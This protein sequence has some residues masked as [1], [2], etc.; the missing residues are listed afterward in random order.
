[1]TQELKNLNQMLNGCIDMGLLVLAELVVL[2]AV[3]VV[4]NLQFLYGKMGRNL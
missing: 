3:Q 4:Q 1:M 2:V